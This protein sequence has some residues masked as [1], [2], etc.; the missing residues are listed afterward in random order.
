MYN[1]SFYSKDEAGN[2]VNNTLDEKGAEVRFVVDNTAPKVIIDGV[3]AG[4]V[5]ATNAQDVNVMVTDNFM[6]KEA[7]F[8]LV[9]ELG[10]ELKHWN[11][12]ELVEEEGTVAKITIPEYDGKQ[13]LLFRALDEAGNEIIT[14]P[15]SEETPT[16]FLVSTNPFVQITS[17]P[18]TSETKRLIIIIATCAVIV[19]G[20]SVVCFNKKKK[21]NK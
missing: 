18:A 21:V 17:T 2:E 5:Y 1:I 3:E 10:E 15:D 13:S 8:Y 14:L 11:Y 19:A 12:L 6:L 20:I 7:E 9:N 16:G 4:E